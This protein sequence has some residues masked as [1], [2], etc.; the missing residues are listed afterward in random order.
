MLQT[1]FQGFCQSLASDVA[2]GLQLFSFLG[3]RFPST[4][5]EESRSCP[6]PVL[7]PKQAKD[8]PCSEDTKLSVS[9]EAPH[10]AP[11][12]LPRTV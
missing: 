10:Y 9:A 5:Q 3:L 2:S 8:V 1:P 6:A 7:E 11:K 12:L 4:G